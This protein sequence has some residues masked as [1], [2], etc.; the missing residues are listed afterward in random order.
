MVPAVTAGR[1]RLLGAGALLAIPSTPRR[2]GLPDLGVGAEELAGLGVDPTAFLRAEHA[3]G[4]AGEV[5]AIPLHRDGVETVLLVGTGDGSPAA[6]R[7]AAA[8]LARRA[9]GA[10][11]LATTL[12]AGRDAEAVRAIAEGFGLA[13]YRF[14]AAESD[15]PKLR[16]IKLILDSPGEVRDSLRRASA[17]VAA[18]RVARDLANQPSLE[19]TPEWLAQRAQEECS[20]AGVSVRVLTDSELEAAGF[21]GIAAVGR[22]SARPPRLL[23]A[24]W[25]PPGARRHVVLVGKGITFDSGGLSLK[26]PEGMP[27]MKTDMAGGAVVIATMSA[28]AALGIAVKV[29]ALV[30]MAENMPGA[31]AVRPGD[32]IRHYGGITSE[33]LN[34]DAEGRLVLADALA[35]AAAEL[36]PDVMIDIATLTGAAYLGLGK[37]H[38]AMYTTSDALRDELTAAAAAGGERVWSMP[39]IE[40]Y[41]DALDSDIADLRNIGDPAKH[42]SGGSIT[43]ALFLREFAGRVPWAHFD[44]A[45]PARSDA[46]EDEVSKGAT[47]FGV[48]TFLRWLE[49]QSA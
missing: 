8:A 6:L 10:R 17:T 27:A 22:G 37:R 46:D 31:D 13:T 7:K 38:G 41:R 3:T 29:T 36:R 32:V 28:L 19:K 43:A 35:Y 12:A 40:D 20:A 15:P 4:K 42:Y 2:R 34:T 48:R 21:G 16:R 26:P 1:G 23:E 44:V 49:S 39:L 9:K 25:D 47:G 18:V 45:G 33:V 24:C 5:V 30:P 14:A 11:S